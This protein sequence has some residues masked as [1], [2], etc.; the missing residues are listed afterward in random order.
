MTLE[1]TVFIQ[2][3]ETQEDSGNSIVGDVIPEKNIAEK[4]ITSA[5]VSS[6]RGRRMSATIINSSMKLIIVFVLI[7]TAACAKLI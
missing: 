2:H 6:L 7:R 1:L 4:I 3:K 5:V